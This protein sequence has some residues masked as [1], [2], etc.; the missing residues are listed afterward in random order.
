MGRRMEKLLCIHFKKCY[1]AVKK[2]NEIQ[3]YALTLL[4]LIIMLS[5]KK[6]KKNVQIYMQFVI[7][8]SIKG[9]DAGKDWRQEK[10]WMTE[11]EMV[12]LHHQLN[13]HEFERTRGDGKGQVREAWSATVHGVAKSQTWL[14]DW[15][16]FMF[17]LWL[18]FLAHSPPNLGI[19]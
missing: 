4:N 12:R 7:F 13:G 18:L 5:Q 9:L 1:I 11:D 14:S 16:K 10:K 6:L 2:T 8:P 3:L 15:T 19:S 17:N